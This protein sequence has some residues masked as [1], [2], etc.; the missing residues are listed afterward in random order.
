MIR[1]LESRPRN[2]QARS[3]LADQIALAACQAAERRCLVLM[4]FGR[5]HGGFYKNVLKPAIREAGFVA[6]RLDKDDYA[7]NIPALFQARLRAAHAVLVDV[8]G[9]N[10]NV[11]YELGQ[12]HAR[13][14]AHPAVLLRERTRRALSDLPFYLQHERVISAPNTA[15]GHRRIAEDVKKYLRSVG[16]V[17]S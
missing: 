15:R 14:H 5:G 13:N 1:R 7:G 10:P 4:P 6:H 17:R 9:A 12:V 2:A 3:R 8:T 11:M 16:R